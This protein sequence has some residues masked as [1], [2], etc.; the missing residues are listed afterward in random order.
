[1]LS[2]VVGMDEARAVLHR[3]E[4]IEAL[5]REGANPAA[6]LA[7]L[8]DEAQDG[9]VPRVLERGH[10]SQQPVGRERVLREVVGADAREVGDAEDPVR[11]E[12]GGRDLHHHADGLQAQLAAEGREVARLLHGRPVT[13]GEVEAA[14]RIHYD[15][16]RHLHDPDSYWLTISQASRILGIRPKAVRKLLGR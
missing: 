5:E 16:R 3:L 6:M 10:G 4:R 7:E 9:G 12:R 1:M 13:P 8:R 11:E 2:N 15:W 14:A